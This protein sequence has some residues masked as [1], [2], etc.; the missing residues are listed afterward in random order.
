VNLRW[1][2]LQCVFNWIVLPSCYILFNLLFS[3]SFF[4]LCEESPSVTSRFARR[5]YTCGDLNEGVI[6]QEVHL[7]GWVEL[8]RLG[9]FLTLRD[10]YGS[11][12][13]VAPNN[14]SMEWSC[15]EYIMYQTVC[16]G[17][18]LFLAFQIIIFITTT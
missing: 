16:S 18:C 15:S 13:L 1:N 14:V 17:S 4:F 8:K 3:P 7:C 12:Q 6:G 5:T 10:G 11:A 2:T 9:R